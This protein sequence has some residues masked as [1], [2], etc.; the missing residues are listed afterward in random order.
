MLG[1]FMKGCFIVILMTVFFIGCGQSDEQRKENYKQIMDDMK[2]KA[3]MYD[4]KID[5]LQ[6]EVKALK[7]SDKILIMN[8]NALLCHLGDPECKDFDDWKIR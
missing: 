7:E 3:K 5:N 4:A 6:A 8:D 1:G 2:T